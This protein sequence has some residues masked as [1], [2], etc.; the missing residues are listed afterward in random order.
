MA[1]LVT[2]PK[3]GF[4]MQEGT[5]IRWVKQ[6]GD[7][8]NEG[9]VLAEIETDKATVE[10]EAYATGILRKTFVKEDTIV[11]VGA[12]IAIIGGADE[13]I[14]GMD[15]GTAEEEL[16][17]A[18]TSADEA[19]EEKE[20]V[21]EKSEAKAEAPRGTSQPSA[22]GDGLPGGVKASPVARR[23]AADQGI[24]LDQ[25]RGSGPGGRIVKRD[26]EGFSPEEAP[27]APAAAA[28]AKPGKVSV[29]TYKAP[30]GADVEEFELS[31]MR[32][33]V[34][35]RTQESF[36]FVPHFYVTSEIDMGP[37]LKLRKELNAQLSD[38]EK[39][40][41]NDIIV[42]AVAITLRDFP[43]LNT[44]FYGDRLVRH[45]KIN[46]GIAVAVENGLINVVAPNADKRSLSDL[47]VSN[48][49]MIARAREGRIKPDDV[50]GA[51]FT[52]SNLGAYDV[53]HFLAIINPPE[54]AILAVGS[55][56]EVPIVKDGEITVGVRM[57]ATISID[58]RVSDG[59][60]GAQFMKRLK[61]VLENPM[62]IVV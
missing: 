1:E 19:E 36:M 14:S 38:E 33:I 60:E 44:H 54:S 61:E 29:P 15:A 39:I 35:E 2:M 18:D 5:L 9:D 52:I 21:T 46:I 28:A 20:A 26:V 59:A 40:T 47:S 56:Q 45:K 16:P 25:V 10:V 43:N 24:N 42:K 31:R 34:G 32:Q 48:K 50:E 7:Q 4:D 37:A 41:V 22:N 55:A 3:L 6:I 23:M 57:K 30:T 11:E 17:K 13:D 51:T 49:A 53:E 62:R 27:A 58:H 8:V 12:P